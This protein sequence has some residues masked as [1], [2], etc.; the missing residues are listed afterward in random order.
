MRRNDYRIL[1]KSSLVASET[2]NT[3]IPN[4]L[5]PVPEIEIAEVEHAYHIAQLAIYALNDV[6]GTVPDSSIL[7][8][9]Y[10]RKEAV[11]SSQIEGTQSTLDDLLRYESEQVKGVPVD[12]VHEVS[13]YVAALNHGMKRLDEGFPMSMRLVREMHKIL[14]ENSRG[15]AKTP[16]EFRLSQNWI[17]GSRPGNARFVPAPPERVMDLMSDLEK[18]LYNDEVPPLFR[19]ALMHHQFETIHPFLDGNGRIGRL[20]IT[21]FLYWQGCLKSTFLYLSLFFKNNRALYYDKLDSVRN[22]GDWE[23][24]INFFFEGLAVTAED[25]RK[26]LLAVR[27]VFCEADKKVEGIGRARIPASQVLAEFK[28]KPILTIAEIAA[29]TGLSNN[30]VSNNIERLTALGLIKVASERKWG[31]FY[32]YSDYTDLLVPDTEAI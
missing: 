11:L 1:I 24:W 12:D 6:A 20:L 30:A 31:R 18:F 8:Y 16:G 17:G 10:V 3:Y 5:P 7:N 27:K 26:T 13:C 32:A 19:A 4:P 25:A 21:L 28:R 29:N 15:A 22:T 23:E 2:Y 14:L 9:M